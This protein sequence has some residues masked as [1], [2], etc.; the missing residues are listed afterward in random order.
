MHLGPCDQCAPGPVGALWCTA[1]GAFS[2][3]GVQ[4][5]RLHSSCHRVVEWSG[6]LAKLCSATTLANGS[7]SIVFSHP[8]PFWLQHILCCSFRVVSLS[9]AAAWLGCHSTTVLLAALLGS[10]I[11]P[12][13]VWDYLEGR[14]NLWLASILDVGAV[15]RGVMSMY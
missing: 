15:K 7:L 3:S 9:C 10:G 8:P 5:I 6:G 4:V 11:P 1:A 12:T 13:G 2:I 14:T